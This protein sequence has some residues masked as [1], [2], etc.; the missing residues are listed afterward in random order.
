[1]VDNKM[2]IQLDS[3]LVLS[4]LKM[5]FTDCI[6]WKMKLVEAHANVIE[7]SIDIV[8]NLVKVNIKKPFTN[9]A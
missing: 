3:A 2:V 9:H 4:L 5:I 8:K 6:W 7:N 1:M